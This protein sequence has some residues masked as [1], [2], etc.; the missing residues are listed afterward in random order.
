MT[1]DKCINTYY[2]ERA[3]NIRYYP[4]N[5]ASR[6]EMVVE[7]LIEG[8]IQSFM[9]KGVCYDIHKNMFRL[10]TDTKPF[11]IPVESRPT[12]SDWISSGGY[13]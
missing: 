9:V 1:I 11:K 10:M 13:I 6:M 8:E 7:L 3:K 2:A 12:R 5:E 4:A